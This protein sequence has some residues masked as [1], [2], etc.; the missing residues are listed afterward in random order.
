MDGWVKKVVIGANRTSQTT[1]P[2]AI[3]SNM[4]LNRKKARIFFHLITKVPSTTLNAEPVRRWPIY[5]AVMT[6]LNPKPIPMI[7]L[8]LQS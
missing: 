5:T 8:N 7:D 4:F 1:N 3:P 6:L 2:A